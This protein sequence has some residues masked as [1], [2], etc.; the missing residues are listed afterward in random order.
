MTGLGRLS[1]NPLPPHHIEQ[2]L[3]DE[4]RSHV[5]LLVD[6]HVANGIHESA[7]RRAARLLVGSPEQ[8][9]E[10]VRDVRRGAWIEQGWRDVQYGCRMLAKSRGFT[11]IAVL[12]LA[13]GIGA[14]TVVFSIVDAVVIRALPYDDPD[15]VVVLW[16]DAGWAG[17]PKNMPAPGTFNHWRRTNRPFVDMAASANASASLTGDGVPEQILGRATTPN[18]FSVLG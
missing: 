13:L 2:D 16:E 4:I 17:F 7:A 9:K 6:E 3:D 11:L 15:R 10:S 14:N 8:I 18:F 1:R 5:E 12:T